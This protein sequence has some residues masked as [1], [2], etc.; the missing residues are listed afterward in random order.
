MAEN[1]MRTV[2]GYTMSLMKLSYLDKGKI[3]WCPAAYMQPDTQAGTRKAPQ[4]GGQS[5]V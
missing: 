3:F 5:C 4:R 2:T 1:M